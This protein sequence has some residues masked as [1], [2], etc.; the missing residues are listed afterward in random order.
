MAENEVAYM[1]WLGEE[2]TVFGEKG[3]NAMK[4]A[5]HILQRMEMGGSIKLYN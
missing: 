1:L 2:Q 5:G 3:S 4:V